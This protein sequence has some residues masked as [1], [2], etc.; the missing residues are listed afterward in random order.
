MARAELV[1]LMPVRKMSR[2]IQFYTKKL[3][4]RLVSRAPGKMK[5]FWASV[6]LGHQD[7]WLIAPEKRE[8]RTLAYSTFVVSNVKSFV[9]ALQ[10]KGVQFEKPGRGSPESR[11]DG[12][13]VWEPFGGAAF[14]KDSE[15]NLLMVWQGL[16]GM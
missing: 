16:S 7:L 1:T 5:D 6:R 4:G 11:I 3:G 8:K 15:G 13:I 9:R 14:F 12:V 2:A 10:K